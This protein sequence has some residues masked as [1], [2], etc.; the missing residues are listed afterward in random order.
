MPTFFQ[1]CEALFDGD[2]MTCLSP[3]ISSAT[4]DEVVVDVSFKMDDVSLNQSSFK[5]R[6]VQ[7]PSIFPVN[8]SCTALPGNLFTFLLRIQVGLC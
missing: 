8:T 3:R 1:D 5:L 7:A 6:Y 4:Q 2:S